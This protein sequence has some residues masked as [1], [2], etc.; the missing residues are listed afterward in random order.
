MSFTGIML[1]CHTDTCFSTFWFA[2]TVCEKWMQNYEYKIAMD[3][4]RKLREPAGMNGFWRNS[5]SFT[6]IMLR[7]HT[8]TCF[9]NILICWKLYVKKWMQNYEYKIA[10][11]YW[12][13]AVGTCGNER[14]L[15]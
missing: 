7:C 12:Q 10:M 8:D 5:M 1:R 3:I 14:I 13:K 15:T 2:E 9:F 4:D 6:G 11:R